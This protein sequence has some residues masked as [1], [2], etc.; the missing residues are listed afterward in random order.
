MTIKNVSRHW[1]VSTAV[2]RGSP[3]TDSAISD[4]PFLLLSLFP[5]LDFVSALPCLVLIPSSHLSPVGSLSQKHCLDLWV[6][7]STH[8]SWHFPASLFIPFH[9][10][11]FNEYV[12]GPKSVLSVGDT[13]VNQTDKVP[14][15]LSLNGD[16]SKVSK[17][18][19]LTA[20]DGAKWYEENR[21]GDVI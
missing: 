3:Q 4:L 2:F 1:Q 19:N 9:N 13:I 16:R 10:T 7:V 8:R 5:L 6:G 11:T 15:L 18:T 17:W 20:T 12:S 21:Y 14:V